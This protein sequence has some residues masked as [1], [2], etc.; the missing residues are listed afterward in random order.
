[1]NL[2]DKKLQELLESVENVNPQLANYWQATAIIESLGYTDRAI[3]KEFNFPDALSLGKY[4]YERHCPSSARKSLPERQNF[5]RKASQEIGIFI[6]Q[7]SRSFVYA[8]PLIL[9]LLLE[10]AGLNE[11]EGALPPQLASLTTIATLASLCTSGGFVQMISRRGEF[12]LKMGE[13]LQSRRVCFPIFYLGA[14]TSII[15]CCSGLWFG[16]Y[17]GVFADE[18]LILGA[19]YYL[20]LSLLW[21][22]VAIISVRFR[23]G[24]SI[25]LLALSV[26]FLYLRVAMGIGALEAQILATLTTLGGVIGL[27]AIAFRSAKNRDSS[28]SD[29]VKLPRLSALVY[30]VYPYFF[31]GIGYFSFIF[32]D[33]LVAGWAISP[34][35]GL[36]FAINSDYQRGMDL[37]LLNFLLIVP[38]I[39]YL[40]YKFIRY[41]YDRTK[42]LIPI[43]ILAFS[44]HIQ[45]LYGIVIVVTVLFF[46]L[47]AI[48]TVSKMKPPNLGT[49]EI[50]QSLLGSL[51]Y[52]LFAIAL[53]NGILLFSL[54]R[55]RSVLAP[56]AIGLIL[57]VTVGY[58]LAHLIDASCAAIGLVVGAFAFMILS[59]RK[60]FQAIQHPDYAYYLGGY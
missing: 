8:I 59:S 7:F 56:L 30:L 3:Q 12:Y 23:W 43:K 6:E 54:N 49:T 36:I 17:R 48:L 27:V 14:A 11:R 51:G 29:E 40:S 20:L 42:K 19:I 60:V 1:M 53:L 16:F 15:L 46:T 9:I 37:A 26:L 22:L 58:L 13:P 32:V 34:A 47:S 45:Y 50:S 5:W 25:V 33:R 4:I 52:L 24:S 10:Y 18:Y 21:M 38:W 39:E 31:Y 2:P 55:A 41:W 28:S 57:N 35:S 44:K